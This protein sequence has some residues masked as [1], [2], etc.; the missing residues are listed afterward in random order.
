MATH[1]VNE[2]SRDYLAQKGP[3]SVFGKEVDTRERLSKDNAVAWFDRVWDSHLSKAVEEAEECDVDF[4]R[5]KVSQHSLPFINPNAA[6]REFRLSG[7]M[8]ICQLTD[9]QTCDQLWF[10]PSSSA[11]PRILFV[12]F[13][14]LPDKEAFDSTAAGLGW[15]PE[16]LGLKILMDFL[17]TMR[18]RR[19]G[20][21]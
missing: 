16:D 15:K 19:V 10:I 11:D 21:N 12:K 5:S 13:P 14:T 3:P 9:P 4:V 17:D 1:F 18:R 20:G 2:S 7:C 8:F 6:H